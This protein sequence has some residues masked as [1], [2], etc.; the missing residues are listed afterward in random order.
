MQ[1]DSLPNKICEN[2]A[3]KVRS[4]CELKFDLL[5]SQEMMAGCLQEKEETYCSQEDWEDPN[6]QEVIVQ[7]QDEEFMETE[8]IEEA[9]KSTKFEIEQNVNSRKLDAKHSRAEKCYLCDVN[10]ENE[11]DVEHFQKNH[12]EI[13]LTRCE[14]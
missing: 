6:M 14:F 5:E 10:F 9:V 8:D 2:C 4:A 11:S 1:D 3:I 7:Y 12:K 13:K